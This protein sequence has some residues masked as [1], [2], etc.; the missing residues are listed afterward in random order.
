MTLTKRNVLLFIFFIAFNFVVNAQITEQT[1]YASY[2]HSAFQGR[3]TSSGEIFDNAKY[4]AAHATLPF[5]T[6]VKVTNLYNNKS[7]VVEINDRCPKYYNRIIDL[8]QAAAKQIDIILSGIANV[9]IEVITGSDLNYLSPCPDSILQNIAADSISIK[10]N[11]I[12]KRFSLSPLEQFMFG[13]I[14]SSKLKAEK[15]ENHYR[16]KQKLITMSNIYLLNV[17]NVVL[18]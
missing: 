3:Y 1:G 18:G 10:C 16:E 2:Y 5:H 11:I 6:L 14:I 17:Q 9:K 8:S 4:T 13:N 7:V 15:L 12:L